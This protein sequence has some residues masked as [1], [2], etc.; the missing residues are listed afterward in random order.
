[1]LQLVIG[2]SNIFFYF[3]FFF[4]F[5]NKTIFFLLILKNEKI[6][7]NEVEAN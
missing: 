7:F 4:N 2:Y 3:Y 6:I 1:M 5:F